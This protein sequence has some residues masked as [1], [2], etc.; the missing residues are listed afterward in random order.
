MQPIAFI[1]PPPRTPSYASVSSCI[2][3]S[4]INRR[5]DRPINRLTYRSPVGFPQSPPVETEARLRTRGSVLHRRRRSIH[6]DRAPGEVAWVKA[7]AYRYGAGEYARGAGGGRLTPWQ[8]IIEGIIV[9]LELLTVLLQV[10]DM[11]P[12]IRANSSASCVKSP[13]HPYL[14]FSLAPPPPA[15]S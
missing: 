7:H 15:L 1:P 10:Y 4:L 8:N 9:L 2:L 12:L 6:S 3:S 13:R 5:I 11:A 14:I